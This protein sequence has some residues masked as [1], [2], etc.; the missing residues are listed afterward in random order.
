MTVSPANKKVN[1]L[2]T[3]HNLAILGILNCD[4]ILALAKFALHIWI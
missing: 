3:N 4:G 1:F 2:R